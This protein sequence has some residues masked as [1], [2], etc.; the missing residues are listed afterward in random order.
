MAKLSL[1][2]ELAPGEAIGPGKVR[3]LELIGETGSIAAAGRAMGMSYR[4]AWLLVDA[5]NRLFAQP[6]VSTAQGGKSGGGA[7]VTGFGQALIGHYRGIER[8]AGDA[9]GDHLRALDQAHRDQKGSPQL[10]EPAAG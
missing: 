8:L 4:R 10:P 6:V 9:A 1:R 5:L 3:L 2:I 7:V